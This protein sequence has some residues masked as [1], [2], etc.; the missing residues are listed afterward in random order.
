MRRSARALGPEALLVHR[1]WIERV[2]RALVRGDA[3][4]DDLSQQAWV[5]LLSR[6]PEREPERLRGWLRSVLRFKAIDARRSAGA[7]SRHETAAARD[8]REGV[9]PADVVA[10]A[11]TID[12]VAHAVLELDEPYRTTVLLRW[13]EDL[14]PREISKRQGIPVETV[15]TRLKRA[16]ARLRTRLDADSGGDRRAWCLALLPFAGSSRESLV[17]ATVTGGLAMGMKTWGAAA[18][19]LL[20]LGLGVTWFRSQ[21]AVETSKLGSVGPLDTGVGRTLPRDHRAAS[22]ADVLPPSVDLNACDRDLDLHGVVVASDGAPVAGARVATS[23]FRWQRTSLLNMEVG[24]DATPGPETRTAGDGTFSL[25]LRRGAQVLLTASAPGFAPTELPACQAGERVRVVLG[26]GVRLILHCRDETGAPVTGATVWLSPFDPSHRVP[27][28]RLLSLSDAAG[29]CVVP[30]VRP[31]ST[32][33]VMA[34]HPRFVNASDG[35]MIAIPASGTAEQTLQFRK[36]RMLRGRVTDAS[37]AT[38][39]QGARINTGWSFTTWVETDAEGRFELAGA[40]ESDFGMRVRAAGYAESQARLT[41]AD[42]YDV[43]LLRGDRVQGRLVGPDGKPVG[44]A[45]IGVT[46]HGGGGSDRAFDATSDAD[47][48]FAVEDLRHD[49]PHTL[50][51]LAAG[52]GRY[53]LDFDPAAQEGGTIDVGDVALPA[54]RMIEGRVVDDG[55]APVPGAAVRLYGFNEDRERLRPGK[56]FVSTHY[57]CREERRTD[58]LGRF[59]FPELCPGDYDLDVVTADVRTTQTSVALAADRDVAGVELKLPGGKQFVVDV[60]DS[61]GAPAAGVTVQ[62]VIRDGWSGSQTTQADGRVAFSVTSDVVSLSAFSWTKALLFAPSRRVE[63]GATTATVV[64][65]NARAV[66]GRIVDPEGRRLVPGNVGLRVFEGGRPMPVD[67]WGQNVMGTFNDASFE[68]SVPLD[69]A[70][71]LV[72]D[73][74]VASDGRLLQGELRGIRPDATDVVLQT[75]IV[76]LDRELTVIVLNPDGRPEAGAEVEASI[77]PGRSTKRVV[78]GPTGRAYLEGLPAT[79]VTIYATLPADHPH[80]ADWIAAS[81]ASARADAG[82]V[83]LMFT[84]GRRVAGVVRSPDG[85]PLKGASVWVYRSQHVFAQLMS[86]DDGRFAFP[87]PFAES[88]SLYL[89]AWK[90]PADGVQWEA[91]LD[92]IPDSAAELELTLKLAGR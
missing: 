46:S 45:L 7:R 52:L 85:R 21:S 64:L 81:V 5:E 25:R 50:T 33:M 77:A 71:D 90:Q 76:P 83:E 72:V 23:D 62:V 69:G 10:R 41:S 66:R 20:V 91:R 44:E 2:A 51:F 32:L 28:G 56:S 58:D 19:A 12:R 16:L 17:S 9:D 35:G 92:G 27:S 59:R 78:A 40:A 26:P 88:K 49:Q 14:P 67:P 55:G 43:A 86:D 38:P 84:E 65:R 1:E 22:Q 70:I 57:G 73:P 89:L 15:R 8:A 6:P 80:R 4:A 79:P 48:R 61:Q 3:D 13:F 29:D 39:V 82:E 75:R 74:V 36:A 42:T 31:S 37:T 34:V 87:A 24:Y 60:K 30:S 54:A 18:V 68:A 11:E 63:A 47:G 53:L